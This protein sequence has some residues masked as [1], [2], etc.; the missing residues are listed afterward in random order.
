MGDHKVHVPTNTETLP[1]AMYHVPHQ[2]SVACGNLGDTRSSHPRA[3]VLDCI[4]MCR[5]G[6][7]SDTRGWAELWGARVRGKVKPGPHRG[8]G[9]GS[10][11]AG[12][13]PGLMGGG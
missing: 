8:L 6:S 2:F 1:N 13:K 10:G 11:R 7:G 12:L 3:K 5:V 4:V 9:P